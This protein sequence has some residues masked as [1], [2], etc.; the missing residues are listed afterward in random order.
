[1][2]SHI[3]FACKTF[4][5]VTVLAANYNIDFDLV[6]VVKL[7]HKIVSLRNE[8]LFTPTK[9]GNS[10]IKCDVRF[11]SMEQNKFIFQSIIGSAYTNLN[12]KVQVNI[13]V[14]TT[15][16]MLQTLV[17]QNDRYEMTMIF[18]IVLYLEG[19]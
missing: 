12:F 4:T 19:E 11:R 3:I 16:K 9:L 5:R 13:D 2:R 6:Y 1:M 15:T 8:M 14:T 17:S 7:D 10:D 18:E